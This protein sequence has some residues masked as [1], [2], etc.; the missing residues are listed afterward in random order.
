MQIDP[1][2][3]D[4]AVPA[5]PGHA[6]EVNVINDILQA[7]PRMIRA[8]RQLRD[9]FIKASCD[10]IK[11]LLQDETTAIREFR[12]IQTEGEQR[13]ARAASQVRAERIEL[14]FRRELLRT[15]AEFVIYVLDDVARM[16]A[17]LG[18]EN[19]AALADISAL[20]DDE[21]ARQ[22]ATWK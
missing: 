15:R 1:V 20:Y 12:M 19:A 6:N 18:A 4:R 2:P 16:I 7:L 21:I 9:A 13:I 10:S 14:Q 11:L 17:A 5:R 8:D 3:N 22:R